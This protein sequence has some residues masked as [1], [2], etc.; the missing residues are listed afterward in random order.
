MPLLSLWTRYFRPHAV[1]WAV[2]AWKLG[3]IGGW[4][5]P[6]PAADGYFFD[7]AVI[8]WLLHG[9]YHNPSII[10][11][12]PTSGSELFSAYPPG[13]QVVLAAWMLLAGPTL[14][15]SLWLH[16]LLFGLFACLWVH[17]MVREGVRPAAVNL[18]GAFLLV[19]TFHDRPDSLAQV[20]GLAG[21]I[22][23][24]DPGE[25]AGRRWWGAGLIGA[26]LLTSLHI[27]AMYA[28]MTWA[29]VALRHPVGRWPWGAMLAMG[30]LPLLVFTLIIWRWPV[31]W[32]GFL[33]NIVVTPSFTGWRVPAGDEVL[34]VLR[35]TAGWWWVA[36]E[37]I[38]RWSRGGFT[39][40][41]SRRS[42]QLFVVVFG[43]VGI[44]IVAT[45]SVV[46][47]NYVW[48]AG[49]AQPLVV[50]LW[51]H[52][53]A[54]SA[55]PRRVVWG[56]LVALI[57]LRALALSTWGVWCA[58]DVSQGEAY[59]RVRAEVERLPPGE[60]AV[61][62]TAFLYAVAADTSRHYHHP[63][64]MGGLGAAPTGTPARLMIF[65]GM[66]FHRR[67]A[68]E[69]AE[70]GAAGRLR[71]VSVEEARQRPIPEDFPRFRRVV[72]HLSWAPVVVWLE[73]PAAN[74]F[75]AERRHTTSADPSDE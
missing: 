75:S 25:R 73:Y 30:A 5:L 15:A 2:V 11:L 69:L 36:G 3:L 66:D 27:G 46:S 4:S 19:L 49:Y 45:L 40:G 31:A 34:R 26:T 41:A 17:I 9:A 37:L 60:S 56:G 72:Q 14:N 65:T 55:V 29:W 48:V 39:W 68:R 13:Y 71:I 22:C 67:F 43:A 23:W 21:L 6:P 12:F 1:V 70:L 74:E 28:A 33:E 38:W 54:G 18:G 50:G 24:T 7:G 58:L 16:G 10:G 8:H 44:A 59:E 52:G 53:G 20:L 61:I 64:W 57:S 62:S 35:N 47:A 63:D 42:G 32:Q 51:W